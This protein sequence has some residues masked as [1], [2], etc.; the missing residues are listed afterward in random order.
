MRTAKTDQTGQMPRLSLQGLLVVLL[1]L[2]CCGSL[3][4]S[5]NRFE[6]KFIKGISHACIYESDLTALLR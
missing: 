2:S 1:V 6:D 5:C 4:I 3:C